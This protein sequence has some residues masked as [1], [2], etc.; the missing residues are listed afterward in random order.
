MSFQSSNPWSGRP[1]SADGALAKAAELLNAGKYADA[2]TL[3]REAIQESPSEPVAH[4]GLGVALLH[5]DRYDEAQAALERAIEIDPASAMALDNLGVLLLNTGDTQGA[6]HCFERAITSAPGLV[7]S[8]FNLSR[9]KRY[10]GDDPQLAQMEAMRKRSPDARISFALG[11]A[12]EDLNRID[13][14]FA[15]YEEGNRIRAKE[16]KYSILAEQKMLADIMAFF[17]ADIPAERGSTTPRPIF[18]VGMPRS[19][20]SLV[21]QILA[22]HPQVFGGGELPAMGGMG[23][24]ALQRKETGFAA[25]IR[26]AYLAQFKTDRPVVTDKMPSNFFWVGFILSA[27]PE[28]KIINIERDPMAVG[29]SIYKNYFASGHGYSCSFADIAA[30]Y[31]LYL[32]AIEFWR[33]KFPGAIYTLNYEQLTVNQE[34]ETRRLLDYCGLDWNENCLRFHETKRVVKTLSDSQVRKPMYSGSSESWRAFAPHLAPLK[35]ALGV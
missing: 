15:M 34:D 3:F 33:Q 31:R 23:K 24:F 22:S 14:S 35:I 4:T 30:Y 5:L 1:A 17:S 29:W 25:P 10:A 26:Q 21:E 19:G 27:F 9:L 7:L 13:E 16:L 18:I 8:H 6:R 28:A 12:Y 11:K 20:T 32:K 2:A